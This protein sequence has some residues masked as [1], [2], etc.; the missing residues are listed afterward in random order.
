M[1]YTLTMILFWRMILMFARILYTIVHTFSNSTRFQYIANV[2]GYL[3]T[4][5]RLYVLSACH[6]LHQQY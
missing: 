4:S 2:L 1:L 6:I 5:L 3:N